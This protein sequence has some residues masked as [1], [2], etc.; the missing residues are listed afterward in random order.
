[1]KTNIKLFLRQLSPIADAHVIC[2][3]P[4]EIHT[5]K[6]SEPFWCHDIWFLTNSFC[7]TSLLYSF[8][9]IL[10]YISPLIKWVAVVGC[11]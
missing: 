2:F 7:K 8:I 11:T 5:K 4:V 10:C 9:A 3:F 1:V 6:S